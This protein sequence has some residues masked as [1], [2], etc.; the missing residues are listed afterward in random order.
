M[1]PAEVVSE[2]IKTVVERAKAGV[3]LLELE[4][5]AEVAMQ[6]YGAVSA[7][8]G[9]Q[10]AWATRPFPG[11]LCL[12]VNDVIAHGIPDSYQLKDG[13]LLSIDSGIVLDG[14]CADA[15]TTIP[16]GEVSNKDERLLC[17]AQRALYKGI[18][19]VRPGVKVTKIG[20]AIE[21]YARQMGYV[22]NHVFFG[23]GI[24]KTMHEG[25]QI[26]HFEL[27]RKEIKI[28]IRPGKFKYEYKEPEGIPE[29]SEGQVICIE[30]MLT[31]KDYTGGRDN[32]GWTFRTRDGKNSAMF[33]SMVLVT[34]TGFEILTN[35]LD[36]S[37]C[38]T[39]HV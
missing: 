24:G 13:D 26:P 27:P 33:E 32:D 25:L 21:L 3:S 37:D 23:H 39:P 16:I 9:Y 22:V 29:L 6:L 2:V 14:W 38:V 15:A 17:Y 1:K 12:G 35:H 10:R 4:H 30:P 28:E 11:A 18:E 19:V 31:Y 7:D 36:F 34:D 5:T 20:E 8:K